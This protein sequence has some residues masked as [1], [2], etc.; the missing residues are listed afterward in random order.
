M[1]CGKR[2]GGARHRVVQSINCLVPLRHQ[3]LFAVP[4]SNSR[5]SVI[6]MGAF[7]TTSSWYD[8]WS[9]ATDAL[10]QGSR[11]REGVW[12]WRRRGVR[13]GLGGGD[14][15]RGVRVIADLPLWFVPARQRCEAMV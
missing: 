2:A 5:D 12:G 8:G 13:G 9:G 15:Y 3:R 7:W 11:V 1:S 10:M 6:D 4:G 14:E